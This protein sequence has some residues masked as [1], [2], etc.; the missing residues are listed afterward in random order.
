MDELE[1]LRALADDAVAGAAA[2]Q[3]LQA[4]Y[5]EVAWDVREPAWAKAR[6]LLLHLLAAA[7]ELARSVEEVEH[8]QQRGSEVS[9]EEFRAALAARPE[10]GAKLLFHAA[11]VATL[12]GVDLG[13][14]LVRLHA[15]GAARFAPGS[16]FAR[17]GDDPAGAGVSRARP[18]DPTASGTA[19]RSPARS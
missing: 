10:L 14:E 18:Q 3:A 17:L 8:A 11:Q 19:P 6:H 2:I 12:S 7:S 13:A 5:D 4:R 15:R 1:A 16:A 9:S